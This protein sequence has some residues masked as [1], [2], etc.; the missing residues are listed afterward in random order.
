MNVNSPSKPT[1]D[2]QAL[3]NAIRASM[4]SSSDAIGGKSPQ[5]IGQSV[6]DFAK[7]LADAHKQANPTLYDQS[8]M[9]DWSKAMAP[10]QGWSTIARPTGVIK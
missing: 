9:F 10:N 2:Q 1:F 7:A 4:S 8:G 6:G 3:V 5:S